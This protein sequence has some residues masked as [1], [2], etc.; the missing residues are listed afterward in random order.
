MFYLDLKIKINFLKVTNPGKSKSIPFSGLPKK[1]L[2]RKPLRFSTVLKEPFDFIETNLKPLVPVQPF[3]ESKSCKI[4]GLSPGQ[5]TDFTG[6]N[7]NTIQN[8]VLLIPLENS[9]R[10]VPHQKPFV[11]YHIKRVYQIYMLII[12]FDLMVSS[13][14]S[15]RIY[16]LWGLFSRKNLLRCVDLWPVVQNDNQPL[17]IDT[18]ISASHNYH[19]KMASPDDSLIY[20]SKIYAKNIKNKHCEAMAINDYRSMFSINKMHKNYVYFLIFVHINISYLIYIIYCLHGFDK[21]VSTK[22]GFGGIR[23][24]CT[25]TKYSKYICTK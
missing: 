11:F 17:T 16:S 9:I 23:P 19:T 1:S 22:R 5:A 8:D 20:G 13:I 6:N 2:D 14:P 15:N 25:Y 12:P 7:Q 21:C 24:P 10:F 3:G 18:M 4:Q